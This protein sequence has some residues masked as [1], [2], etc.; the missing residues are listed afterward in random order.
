MISIVVPCY[1]EQEALNFFYLELTGITETLQNY[2]FEFVFVDDGSHDETLNII[3]EF[4]SLDDRVKY[5]SFSRNFGKESAMFAGLKKAD[6]DYIAIMDADMQ[7]PPS[8][9]PEMVN[10][11]ENEGYDSV[12]TRRVSR[13]GEPVIRSFFARSFYKLMS[14]ISKTDIVDGARDFRLMKRQMVDAVT[15]L[16]EYNRFSKGI[17][18]WVGFKTKWLPF[19]NV[20]RIA[21]ET[22]WSFW[23]L[24]RYSL[25]GIIGFSSL[26]LNVAAFFGG[27]FC[28]VSIILAGVI[29]VDTTANGNPVSGWPSIACLV[30][31]LGGIQLFC[32]GV[33][34]RYLSKTYSEVKRRP[35]FIVKESN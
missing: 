9:L 28:F 8:L 12:A 26:P 17:F 15:S 23:S 24:F 34:G 5:I 1:N 33:L 29:I 7:D 2:S 18:G 20:E 6:G 31:F 10:A 30:L 3:K 22:K 32:I 16:G 14:K 13:E 35:I 19:V 11:L 27:F 25:E 4:S 21:G